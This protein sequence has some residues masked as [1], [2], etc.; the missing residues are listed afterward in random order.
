MGAFMLCFTGQHVIRRARASCTPDLQSSR[1]QYARALIF[2]QIRG[3]DPNF[4][5]LSFSGEA[6]LWC[7][8]LFLRSVPVDHV[9]IVL[10]TVDTL[11]VVRLSLVSLSIITTLLGLRE[12][13]IGIILD[14]RAKT[15]CRGCIQAE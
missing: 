13:V 4:V 8:R 11:D 2:C 1:S 7:S 15:R 12:Q 14:E 6:R 5:R 10:S 9:M 3:G